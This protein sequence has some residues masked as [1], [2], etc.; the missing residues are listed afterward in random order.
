MRLHPTSMFA[1]VIALG[2]FWMGCPEDGDD[3]DSSDNGQYS[4][5]SQATINLNVFG[6][7][8]GEEYQHFVVFEGDEVTACGPQGSGD[9]VPFALESSAGL[10]DTE[11]QLE[12]LPDGWLADTEL[13]PVQSLSALDDGG[14]FRM[15]IPELPEG[16]FD[17][18][19][20]TC[21]IFIQ[22]DTDSCSNPDIPYCG[23]FSC[24][25]GEDGQQELML[26]GVG[27][28]VRIAGT[29]NCYK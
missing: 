22:T 14:T 5:P 19:E 16:P 27:D 17:W 6:T 28:S 10:A 15:T 11:G 12:L 26:N 3:D 9:V 20:G 24:G 1:M 7:V 2:L 8:G 4:G 18:S 29:F 23:N 21:F 25:G 13:H